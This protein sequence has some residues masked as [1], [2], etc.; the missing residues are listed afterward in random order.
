MPGNVTNAAVPRQCPH[1]YRRLVPV[2]AWSAPVWWVDKDHRVALGQDRHCPCILPEGHERHTAEAQGRPCECVHG[3]RIHPQIRG[4]MREQVIKQR[5]S[6][7][8]RWIARMVFGS[9][10]EQ[11]Q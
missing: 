9:C 6:G 10:L 4:R 3:P 5:H 8:V 2:V 11:A 1:S 7:W